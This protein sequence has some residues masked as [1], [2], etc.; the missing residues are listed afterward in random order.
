MTTIK[1]KRKDK[2]DK[3]LRN[4][5]PTKQERLKEEKIYCSECGEELTSERS[6]RL[7]IGQRCKWKLEE[8]AGTRVYR[9]R[10]GP[11]M[12]EDVS[13]S[14]PIQGKEVTSGVIVQFIQTRL[15]DF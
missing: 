14:N 4:S 5:R 13:F 12:K 2:R 1:T 8:I 15:G 11:H 7:R 3:K 10:S 6:K 9:K